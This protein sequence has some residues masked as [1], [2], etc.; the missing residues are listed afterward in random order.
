M[1]LPLE[2]ESFYSRVPELAC[3]GP[4]EQFVQGR[5]IDCGAALRGYFADASLKMERKLVNMVVLKNEHL[6]RRKP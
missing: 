4:C 5:C 6:P 2:R 1:S 3:V